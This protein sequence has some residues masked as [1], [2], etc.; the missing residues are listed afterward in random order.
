MIRNFRHAR[1]IERSADCRTNFRIVI[2]DERERL[3]KKRFTLAA[4]GFESG[5]F[6]QVALFEKSCEKFLSVGIE[7]GVAGNGFEKFLRGLSGSLQTELFRKVSAQ[8]AGHFVAELAGIH[9][10]NRGFQNLES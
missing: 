2:P 7:D 6:D 9:C 5:K 3:C 1:G 4:P 8:N 10:D